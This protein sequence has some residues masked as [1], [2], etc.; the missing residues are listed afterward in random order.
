MKPV[1]P[2][3]TKRLELVP[4]IVHT[5]EQYLTYLHGALEEWNKTMQD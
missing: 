1:T 5:N 4:N 2:S 3:F